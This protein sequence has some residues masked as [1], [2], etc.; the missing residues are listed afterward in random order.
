M[1]NK[2]NQDTN[3]PTYEILCCVTLDI[4][5]SNRT[6][7]F[8]MGT[9]LIECIILVFLLGRFEKTVKSLIYGGCDSISSWRTL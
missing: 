5:K 4:R 1:C 6:S 3:C 8:F 9:I 7:I 2:S